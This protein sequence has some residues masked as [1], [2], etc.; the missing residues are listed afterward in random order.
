MDELR[1]ITNAYY[2]AVEEYENIMKDTKANNFKKVDEFGKGVS[3][4][5]LGDNLNYMKHLII[6]ENMARKI[7]LVYIDPPFFAREKFMSSIRLKSEK[8]GESPVIKIGA[9]DDNTGRSL[10]EYLEELCLR[11]MMIRELLADTGLIWL[12]LDRRVTHYAKILM[13]MIYGSENFINEIIW[14]YKSGGAGKGCFAKKHDNILAYA[15]GRKYKFNTLKEK[16]YNR[17]MKPYRFKGVEEFEDENGWYTMVNMKDVWNI[18]MVGRTSS[19][20]QG[21]A[22]QKPEKLMERI[23]NSCSDKGDICADFYSGSGAFPAVCDRSGRKWI[24]CDSNPG[25]LTTQIGRMAE[26]DGGFTVVAENEWPEGEVVVKNG[27]LTDYSAPI[28]NV[29]SSKGDT[30]AEYMKEDGRCFIK[31]HRTLKDENGNYIAGY[32]ILGNRFKKYF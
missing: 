11:L 26:S 16:S 14:T 28:D 13:D 20:R 21:Y 30:L 5:A 12:H 6:N 19:E 9:Y 2:R 1:Q 24:S 29:M 4:I 18:D 23:I 22:T 8:L 32:D 27:E 17:G 15:K 3:R 7:Q 25:A 10:E 31:F